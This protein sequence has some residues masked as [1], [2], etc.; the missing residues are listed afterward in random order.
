MIGGVFLS[1]SRK[2]SR[3]VHHLYDALGAAG[4]DVWLDAAKIQPRG[5][6]LRSIEVAIRE[7]AGLVFVVTP[8]SLASEICRYERRYALE[9]GKP[10]VGLFPDDPGGDG[11]AGDLAATECVLSRD[12]DDLE[13]AARVLIETVESKKL[14]SPGRVTSAQARRRG[15][16]RAAR[17]SVS[18]F[19]PAP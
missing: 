12:R 5:D 8:D 11:L 6:W 10:I 16:A 3:F 14:R 2:D 19:A 1:Y 13:A 17:R 18:R 7:T 4:G 15:S 9:H